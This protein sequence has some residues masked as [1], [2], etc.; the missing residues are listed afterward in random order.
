M[1][2]SSFLVAFALSKF[3]PPRGRLG[4]DRGPA[5]VYGAALVPSWRNCHR[6]KCF[7]VSTVRRGRIGKG[8]NCKRDIKRDSLGIYKMMCP[9]SFEMAHGPVSRRAF[10][11]SP[12]ALDPLSRKHSRP[13][14]ILA[15]NRA[16]IA[17]YFTRRAL[18][19]NEAD[20][21]DEYISYPTYYLPSLTYPSRSDHVFARRFPVGVRHRFVSDLLGLSFVSN[22]IPVGGPRY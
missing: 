2:L 16:I 18:S 19:P 5:L 6:R 9:A 4:M 8:L 11:G 13:G 7:S 1:Y 21:G 3:T 20:A 22:L 10:S 15:R 12:S 14:L 17:A